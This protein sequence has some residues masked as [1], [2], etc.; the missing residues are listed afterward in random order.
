MTDLILQ[1]CRLATMDPERPGA[2]GAV[3]DAAVIIR[4]G[5]IAWAGPAADMVHHAQTP[6]ATMSDLGG[7]LVTPA[8]VDCHTH[9][10]FGGDRTGEFEQRLNGVS[11]EEIAK[12]GGGIRSTVKATRAASLEELTEGA[13]RRLKTLRKG[14][15]A[16]VEVKSG[17]GLDVETEIRMLRAATAAAD[18]CGMRVRRTHLGLHALPPEYADRRADYVRLICEEALPAAHAEGLVDA[19]DAFCETIGFTPDE[20]RQVFE[21]A[22][23][24]GLPVRLHAEQLSDQGGA[25]LAAEFEALSADHLEFLDHSGIAAMVASGTVAVLLPG[26]FYFIRET[27]RPPVQALRD[28]GVP[29]AIATDLNPGSSPLLSPTLVLN[30]A[31]TLFALTPEEAI[32]GM[33]REAARAMGVGGETGMIREGCAADLAVWDVARPAEIAYWIG[34]PGP[35]R[36]FIAGQEVAP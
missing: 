18:Q 32:A 21:K 11:Y 8:L 24:L 36:L 9:S 2:Y 16:T 26:A 19:V 5:K 30:M 34:L 15:V 33:T 22:R 28:A 7:R 29:I 4:G 23:E 10:V 14:G 27:K 17:Y 1:N 6:P 35:E 20:T 12:A 25:K 13:V 31:C 3:E